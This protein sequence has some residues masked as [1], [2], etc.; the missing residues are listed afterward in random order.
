M[1]FDVT[2]TQGCVCYMYSWSGRRHK[3]WPPNVITPERWTSPPEPA[4]QASG[5]SLWQ[6]E[7]NNRQHKKQWIP[8]LS[9]NRPPWTTTTL[10]ST[11]SQTK[12][13]TTLYSLTMD[14]CAELYRYTVFI[15]WRHLPRNWLVVMIRGVSSFPPAWYAVITSHGSKGNYPVVGWLRCDYV[16]VV[17]TESQLHTWPSILGLAV[18][19]WNDSMSVTPTVLV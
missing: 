3:P 17:L 18:T 14:T 13:I 10:K 5:E 9:E 19:K 12:K 8:I 6:L 16:R 11:Y 4:Q 2:H 7:I 15:I 1:V